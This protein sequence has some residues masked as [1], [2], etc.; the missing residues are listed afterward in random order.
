MKEKI[1]TILRRF[2]HLYRA[3]QRCYGKVLVVAESLAGTN[4]DEKEEKRWARRHLSEGNNWAISGYWNIRDHPATKFL[5]ERIKIFSPFSSVLEVG[6]NC[7]PNLF[8]IAKNFPEVELKGIDIS[9]MAVQRGNELLLKEGL[10]NVKL[11]VG[12]ANDLSQFSDK[13]FDIVFT[14]AVL[15]HIGPSK[16]RKV[17]E[18]MIRVSKRTLILVEYHEPSRKDE[19]AALGIRLGYSHRWKRN[20]LTLLRKFVPGAKINIIKIPRGVWEGE[21]AEMGYL[22][23]VIF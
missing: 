11:L 21:W 14:K 10:L 3:F 2:P 18:E 8:L 4:I 15:S 13:S 12:K 6:C 1:K 7:G 16:I 9:P 19:S 23:E 22:I 17:I 5:A 20:Y